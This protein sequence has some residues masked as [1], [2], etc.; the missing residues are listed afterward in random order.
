MLFFL[1]ICSRDP[2]QCEKF[3]AAKYE[4]L[5]GQERSALEGARRELD[6]YRIKVEGLSHDVNPSIVVIRFFSFNLIFDV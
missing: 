3:E 2:N 5:I 4:A 6:Q 1:L